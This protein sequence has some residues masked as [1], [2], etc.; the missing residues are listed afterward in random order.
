MVVATND[1]ANLGE[2]M[3]RTER[4]KDVIEAIHTMVNQL[5]QF[6][7]RATGQGIQL[8]PTLAG[9]AQQASGPHLGGNK[10]I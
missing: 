6:L 7:V 8:I 3:R 1:D 5:N 10:E 9:P 4:L 2:L